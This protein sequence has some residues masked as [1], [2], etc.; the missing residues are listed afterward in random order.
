MP[1]NELKEGFRMTQHT[2]YLHRNAY[3]QWCCQE[4]H[5]SSVPCPDCT[6]V[7]VAKHVSESAEVGNTSRPDERTYT[8]IDSSI[9]A[10][11]APKMPPIYTVPLSAK[12]NKTGLPVRTNT[13]FSVAY[14]S[15]QLSLWVRETSNSRYNR[16][17]QEKPE[18][19]CR[20]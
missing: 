11:T 8:L 5:Y 18:W 19:T 3:Y 14:L 16:V 7:R 20:D 4:K 2:I 12:I 17:D 10:A 6:S 15:D 13:S 9:V 1:V